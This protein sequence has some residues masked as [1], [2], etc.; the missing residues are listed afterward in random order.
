[1]QQ[2]GQ[3]NKNLSLFYT[4]KIVHI[5]TF[6]KINLVGSNQKDT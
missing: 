5:M 2:S 3:I 6:T 4:I 1:M